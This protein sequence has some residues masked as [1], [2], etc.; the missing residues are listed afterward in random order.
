M[1]ANK[2]MGEGYFL[3]LPFAPVLSTG[4]RFFGMKDGSC[5]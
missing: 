1:K 4:R 3:C 5:T 2:A